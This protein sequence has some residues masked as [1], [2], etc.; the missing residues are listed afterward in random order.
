M[1]PY[2]GPTSGR[3]TVGA[4]GEVTRESFT[5]PP[6]TTEE[7]RA[8]KWFTDLSPNAQLREVRRLKWNLDESQRNRSREEEYARQAD[9]RIKK[10]ERRLAEFTPNGYSVP[11]SANAMIT[12]AESCGWQTARSWMERKEGFNDYLF[13]AL[14]GRTGPTNKPELRWDFKLSW[15][16]TPNSGR[17]VSGISRTPE[18]PQWRDAPPLSEIRRVISTNRKDRDDDTSPA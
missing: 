6:L 17:L 1:Q 13:T 5:D 8:V 16:C 12:F 2:T 14:I 10:L 4:D 9:L 15:S 18:H 11:G 3:V 7:A